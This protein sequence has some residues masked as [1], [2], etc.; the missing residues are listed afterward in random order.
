MVGGAGGGVGDG[1]GV[2]G[3]VGVG[4]GVVVGMGIVVGVVVVV[5]V[6][7]CGGVVWLWWEGGCYFVVF[8]CGRGGSVEVVSA[9][10]AVV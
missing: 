5:V 7:G 2:V 10:A 4:V 1:Y 6:D 8:G 9:A 3:V